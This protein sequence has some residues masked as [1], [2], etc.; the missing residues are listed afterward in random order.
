MSNGV[1]YYHRNGMCTNVFI[2][3]SLGLRPAA[4]FFANH[5]DVLRFI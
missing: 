2:V 1:R 5:I 3:F 4:Y